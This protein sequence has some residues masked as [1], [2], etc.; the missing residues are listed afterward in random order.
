MA[1][2]CGVPYLKIYDDEDDDDDESDGSGS[3]AGGGDGGGLRNPAIKYD[4]SLYYPADSTFF[5]VLFASF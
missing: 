1:L 2:I 3:G 5:S 4:T